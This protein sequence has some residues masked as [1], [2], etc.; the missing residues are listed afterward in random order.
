MKEKKYSC[1][2]KEFRCTSKPWK[3]PAIDL[4]PLALRDGAIKR[5]IKL[6]LCKIL[7]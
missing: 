5:T 2:C 3:S 4:C 1:L 6:L 7:N